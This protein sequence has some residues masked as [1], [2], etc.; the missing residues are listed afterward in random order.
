M[1]FRAQIQL[2]PSVAGPRNAL[3]QKR[4]AF[5]DAYLVCGLRC[6]AIPSTAAPDGASPSVCGPSHT[7]ILSATL[8]RMETNEDLR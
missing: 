5:Y 3:L 6:R 2:L 8:V 7:R 4:A 1:R